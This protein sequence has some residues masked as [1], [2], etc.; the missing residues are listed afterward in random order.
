ME[1]RNLK[2]L[3]LNET[4][5]GAGI[6]GTK[7]WKSHL[8][9]FN[10]ILYGMPVLYVFGARNY[11]H[12]KPE[13]IDNNYY[14]FQIVKETRQYELVMIGEDHDAVIEKGREMQDAFR[15]AHVE[16]NKDFW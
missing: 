12:T 6:P 3:K 14:L 1:F 10:G 11:S 4:I 15:I 7:I 5:S 2:D 16:N 8:E 9:I 13:D